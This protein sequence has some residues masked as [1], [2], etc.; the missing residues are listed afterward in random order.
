MDKRTK[1]LIGVGG[2]VAVVG[3]I[4][5]IGRIQRKSMYTKLNAILDADTGSAKK[6][7]ETKSAF[8]PNSYKTSNTKPTINAAMGQDIIDNINGDY[9]YFIPNNNADVMKQISRLNS[10]TDLSYVSDLWQKKY[11]SPA[12]LDFLNQHFSDLSNQ[13]NDYISG[14][15]A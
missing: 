2:T 14:L 7:Q 6:V 3:G 13:V 1:I 15:P 8:D 5:L 12:L 4:I 9:H 11:G 10:R